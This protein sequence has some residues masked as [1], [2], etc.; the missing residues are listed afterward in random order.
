MSARQTQEL[1]QCKTQT[2]QKDLWVLMTV[3]PLRLAA[4]EKIKSTFT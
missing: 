4:L 2:S 1:K 3:R